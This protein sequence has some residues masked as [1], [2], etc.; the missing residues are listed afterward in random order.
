MSK[1][2]I[3]QA[4][5][6]AKKSIAQAVAPAVEEIAI[7]DAHTAHTAGYLTAIQYVKNFLTNQAKSFGD[8]INELHSH[9]QTQ[10]AN[11]R[12]GIDRELAKRRV[13][14]NGREIRT[15]ITERGP[16]ILLSPPIDEAI[17][18]AARIAAA[19]P[20]ADA[21]SKPAPA[22]KAKRAIKKPAVPPAVK[23]TDAPVAQPKRRGRP[24][25][26]IAAPSLAPVATA[27]A[28]KKVPRAVGA[29]Q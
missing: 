11:L 5:T 10:M 17:A 22:P 6:K 4:A 21:Q 29:P 13:K 15:Q 24:P 1:A 19:A 3:K 27:A 16:L 7:R 20:Q 9:E 18:A 23:A 2:A 25:K 12:L 14:L 8:A 26:T 28:P